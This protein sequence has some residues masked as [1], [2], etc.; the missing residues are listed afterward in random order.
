MSLKGMAEGVGLRLEEI[1][2]S[3]LHEEL[4]HRG[5]LPPI[6]HCTAI[7][8]GPPS[9]ADG[10]TYVGQTWDWMTTVYGLSSMLLWKR[11]GGPSVLAY[12]YPGLW[13]GAGLNSAGIA[14][15]WT[16]AALGKGQSDIAGP[17]VGISSYILIA[18]HTRCQSDW[19]SASMAAMRSTSQT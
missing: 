19:R 2:L 6:E 10:N 5:V 16:S 1:L 14:L 15:T 17:R 4:Y 8:S 13:A 9:T 18:L 11:T 12:A 7:E 3:T